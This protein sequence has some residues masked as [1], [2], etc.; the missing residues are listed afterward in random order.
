MTA[1]LLKIILVYRLIMVVMM[2]PMIIR[3]MG[4]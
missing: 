1:Q 4:Q 2:V 3:C